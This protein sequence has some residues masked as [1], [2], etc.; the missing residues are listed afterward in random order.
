MPETV[1]KKLMAL[2]EKKTDFIFQFQHISISALLTHNMH[3]MNKLLL[4]TWNS[5]LL[6]QQAPDNIKHQI[7]QIKPTSYC[8]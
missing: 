2:I 5:Q 6:S 3:H 1:Q 8:K 4:L 7:K